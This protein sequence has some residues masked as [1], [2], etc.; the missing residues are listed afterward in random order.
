MLPVCP[1]SW[2]GAVRGS[3]WELGP[4]YELSSFRFSIAV[5]GAKYE[6]TTMMNNSDYKS[7]SENVFDWPAQSEFEKPSRGG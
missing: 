4:D 6:R 1:R 2:L 5:H 7:N 3:E